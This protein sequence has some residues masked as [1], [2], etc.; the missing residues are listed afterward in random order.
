MSEFE[1]STIPLP[2]RRRRLDSAQLWLSCRRLAHRLHLLRHWWLKPHAAYQP[3]FV[4]ASAR[5][6]SNLLVDY[7]NRLQDTQSHW[8][9]LNEALA[10]GL[11]HDRLASHRALKHIRHSLQTLN[12]PNRGCKLMLYQMDAC[13]LTLDDL[14]TGFQSPKYIVLYRESLA[15]QFLSLQSAKA[16]NQWAVYKGETPQQ[17][18]ITINPNEFKRYCQRMRNDYEQAL[19][20]PALAARGVLMSYEELAARPAECLGERICPLLGVPTIDPQTSLRKQSTQPLHKRIAN[21]SEV[22][23]LLASPL[24][25]QQY[26]LPGQRVG[27]QSVRRLAA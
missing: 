20:H 16:T 19:N 1:P 14:E 9:I 12:A 27:R 2:K 13:G 15:E 21:Y 5:S 22:A 23:G 6:G 8:E 24:C 10:E 3:V 26:V 18:Q 25:H 4:I 7:L 11:R 17:P